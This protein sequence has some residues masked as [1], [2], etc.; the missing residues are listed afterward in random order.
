LKL[1]KLKR[2][3]SPQPRASFPPWALPG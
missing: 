1:G 2:S 3:A